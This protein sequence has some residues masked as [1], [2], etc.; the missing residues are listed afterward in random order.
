LFKEIWRDFGFGMVRVFLVAFGGF[1]R[2][3][4]SWS[5]GVGLVVVG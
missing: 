5:F 3:F 4:R 2:D 1:V